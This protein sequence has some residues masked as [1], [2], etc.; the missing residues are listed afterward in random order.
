L[1]NPRRLVGAEN[2]HSMQ[3]RIIDTNLFRFTPPKFSFG[4][5]VGTLDGLIGIVVGLDFY[6]E[7]DTWSY[8]IYITDRNNE[9]VEEIWYDTEQLT[10]LDQNQNPFS[11]KKLS[12]RHATLRVTEGFVGEN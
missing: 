8:G 9:L 5:R 12:Q 10:A 7:T 1:E 6:P 3:V 2:R 11:V 4:Q